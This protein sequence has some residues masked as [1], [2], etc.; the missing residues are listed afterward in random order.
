MRSIWSG[1]SEL[2]ILLQ[3]LRPGTTAKAI[4]ERFVTDPPLVQLPFRPFVPVEAQLY[5]PRSIA[6]HFQK[7]RSE[8]RVVEINVV[9]IY[10]NRLIPVEQESPIHFPGRERLRLLLRHTDEY[11][12]VPHR[13]LFPYAI[14]TVVFP[15]AVLEL[16]HRNLILFRV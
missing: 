5:P 9:M 1:P 10:V 14:G 7:W 15:L 16:N 8:V 12:F 13:P 3:L 6:A 4:V 2:Q 11:N